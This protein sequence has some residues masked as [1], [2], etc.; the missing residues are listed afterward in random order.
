ME[1]RMFTNAELKNFRSWMSVCP[2]DR[3][4]EGAYDSKPRRAKDEEPSAGRAVELVMKALEAKL[5]AEGFAE[6]C[7]KICGESDEPEP[8]AKDDDPST[9]FTSPMEREM[10]DKAAKDKKAK[11]KKTAKNSPPD[12][13]GCPKTGAM[14]AANDPRFDYLRDAA[15]VKP[16]TGEGHTDRSSQTRRAPSMTADN[17][18]ERHKA[19]FHLGEWLVLV[20]R[21]RGAP[22]SFVAIESPPQRQRCA[23][24]QDRGVSCCLSFRVS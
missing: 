9:E 4:A 6:L 5:G 3:S 20:R 1:Y 24:S 13:E 19:I 16:G 22:K 23:G 12:F 10:A 18:S 11:D 8:E 17:S 2:F 14:D 7:E 15:K 21:K